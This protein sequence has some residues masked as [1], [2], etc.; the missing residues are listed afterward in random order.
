MPIASWPVNEEPK[1]ATLASPVGSQAAWGRPG[2]GLMRQ[3]AALQAQID[4]CT[5]AAALPALRQRLAEL[6]QHIALRLERLRV[7][8]SLQAC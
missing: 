5:D 1:L 2:A 4:A 3:R 8:P 7:S 6:R